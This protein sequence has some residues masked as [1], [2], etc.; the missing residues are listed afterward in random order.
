MAASSPTWQFSCVISCMN[1]RDFFVG[2]YHVANKTG[3]QGL[4]PPKMVTTLQHLEMVK[5]NQSWLPQTNIA[6]FLKLMID[7]LTKLTLAAGFSNLAAT[8]KKRLTRP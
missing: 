5:F 2:Q 7:V 1:Y 8:F 6:N 3:L 4:N